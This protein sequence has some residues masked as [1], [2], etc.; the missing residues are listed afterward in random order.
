MRIGTAVKKLG[1]R[2]YRRHALRLPTD[3]YVGCG[4]AW[5]KEDN[6]YFLEL[7]VWLSDAYSQEQPALIGIL[8]PRFLLSKSGLV[9]FEG[10]Q[11]NNWSSCLFSHFDSLKDAVERYFDPWAEKWT[12]LQTLVDYYRQL[13]GITDTATEF[14]EIMATDELRE[15]SRE[16]SPPINAYY[17]SILTA[18]Q[19]SIEEAADWA[20]R[21]EAR[22]GVHGEERMVVDDIKRGQYKK[23]V[24]ARV[25][26]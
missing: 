10:F 5:Q 22:G 13:E 11:T 16:Y 15:H 26:L 17:L 3:N 2:T 19:G 8:V 6:A 23:Q 9:P 4:F 25:I 21:F 18:L 24:L 14:T 12:N 7:E 20:G 1:F